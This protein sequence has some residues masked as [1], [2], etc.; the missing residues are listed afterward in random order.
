MSDRTHCRSVRRH[1]RKHSSQPLTLS[2][3]PNAI[4][5]TLLLLLST[6]ACWFVVE[7]KETTPSHSTT[8]RFDRSYAVRPDSSDERRSDD[9]WISF[10]EMPVVCGTCHGI[11]EQHH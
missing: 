3:A 4:V 2:T 7:A 5:G 8:D 6:L 10:D 9:A 1:Y 11:G